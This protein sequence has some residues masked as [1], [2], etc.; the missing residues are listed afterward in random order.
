MPGT[1]PHAMIRMLQQQHHQ[2]HESNLAFAEHYVFQRVAVEVIALIGT[3]HLTHALHVQSPHAELVRRRSFCLFIHFFFLFSNLF[4]FFFLL[5]S[6]TLQLLKM[7]LELSG[8][9]S[10]FI[11]AR[12]LGYWGSFFQLQA[13]KEPVRL[14]FFLFFL[15]LFLLSFYPLIIILLFLVFALC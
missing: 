2:G 6:L 5:S 14:N 11:F 1:L 3:Q 12:A 13:Q 9:A 10:P 8:H 15:F 7:M 4:E